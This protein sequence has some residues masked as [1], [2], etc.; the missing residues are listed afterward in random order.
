MRIFKFFVVIILLFLPI[1][2]YADHELERQDVYDYKEFFDDL[3]PVDEDDNNNGCLSGTIGTVY[4]NCSGVTVGGETLTL[5]QYVAGVIK[6]EFGGSASND[7]NRLNISKVNAIAAR[8]FLMSQ[9]GCTSVI[10]SPSFQVYRGIDPSDHYDQIYLKASQETAG[11]VM[12]KNNKF[13][14][15]YFVTVPVSKYITK[16]GGNWTFHM[17]SDANDPSTAYDYTMPEADIFRISSYTG[18]LLYP[19]ESSGHHWGIPTV[20]AAYEVE[21]GTSTENILK[22]FYGKDISL[23]RL[24]TSGKSGS[25]SSSSTPSSLVCNDETGGEYVSVDGIKF[26]F[27]NYN[28]EGTSDGLGSSFDL[29][30]GNV[31]QCPWYAK[32][33]AI[34]IIETSNLSSDLKEKAKSVLLATNGNG[35]MWYAGTNSTLSYFQYSSD[36]NKAKAGSIIAWERNTHNY[37]HVGIVEKVNS[38]GS[39]V[40][41]EGWNMGGPN[42]ADV[43]SNIKVIT[44]T[45]SLEEV[46][47]YGGTG[48]FIGYTYLFSYKK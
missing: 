44:H 16:S 34:E 6:G 37:G 20:G 24:N 33:R 30:A 19:D 41:S 43:P 13:V 2:V 26:K 46:R 35:N 9:T 1:L 18:G 40:I 39:L 45:M 14:T 12:M 11:I 15:G 23:A 28:I 29:T 22:M 17:L 31:S 38:D 3:Y 7:E 21:K 27:P 48:S 47:T 4:A 10:S 25:N 8:S 42:G 5:D 32:Y 36:I